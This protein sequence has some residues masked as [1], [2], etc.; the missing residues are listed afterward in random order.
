[1]KFTKHIY[2]ADVIFIGVYFVIAFLVGQVFVAIKLMTPYYISSAVYAL[3]M[4]QKSRQNPRI[5]NYRAIINLFRSKRDESM[6]SQA[7]IEELTDKKEGEG[8]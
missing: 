3:L 6:Y 8:N 2:A 7:F 4:V 1:M 5:R